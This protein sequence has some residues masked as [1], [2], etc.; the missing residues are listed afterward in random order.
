MYQQVYMP[1]C[2]PIV[3]GDMNKAFGL[4]RVKQSMIKEINYFLLIGNKHQNYQVISK[5]D[6][7]L[8]VGM[9]L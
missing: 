2:C 4:L 6:K 3:Y 9:V 1:T 5:D 8:L 7:F